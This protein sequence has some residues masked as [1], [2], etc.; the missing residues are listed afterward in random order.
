MAPTFLANTITGH[1]GNNRVGDE[2]TKGNEEQVDVLR[3]TSAEVSVHEGSG[4][5]T[6]VRVLKM[7]AASAARVRL[8]AS[9]QN[10]PNA[11]PL[12]KERFRLSKENS[13]RILG[14]GFKPGVEVSK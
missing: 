12:V 4:R 8:T 1:S 3:S 13:V 11:S 7:A 9:P 10:V 5:H 6:T 14:T 2:E